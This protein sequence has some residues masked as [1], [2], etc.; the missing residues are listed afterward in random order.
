MHVVFDTVVEILRN[1][2]AA[3]L[4]KVTSI[5]INNTVMSVCLRYQ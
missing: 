2:L 3:L 1:T 5:K 4:L